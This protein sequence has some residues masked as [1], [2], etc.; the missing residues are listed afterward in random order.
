MTLY[1][2]VNYGPDISL[3]YWR[4]IS[5]TPCGYWIR[6]VFSENDP[7]SM[8]FNDPANKR[9]MRS[10]AA[11]RFAWPTK[12]EAIYSF[13]RRKAR[14]IEHL[15]NQL[16]FAKRALHVAQGIYDKLKDEQTNQTIDGGHDD[17]K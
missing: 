8:L 3:E 12:R 13:M 9:Y 1:R 15:T 17:T 10:K 5:H 11:R 6:Q 7:A 16:D 4:V 14:Q 2:Y